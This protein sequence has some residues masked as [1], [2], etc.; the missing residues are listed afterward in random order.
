MPIVQTPQAGEAGLHSLLAMVSHKRSTYSR[1]MA[2][3]D[4]NISPPTP[5]DHARTARPS[6]VIEGG[7]WMLSAGL[8][9]AIMIA[10]IRHASKEIHPFEVAF[11]RNLFGLMWM[12][13]WIV[14]V[15][16]AGLK[17]QR[18][19]L[20]TGRAISGTAAMLTWFWA[21]TLM[22]MTEAVA[23]SFTTPFFATIFA[24]LFLGEIVR[25]RR[26]SA[27]AVGFVGAMVI[28]R[29]GVEAIR[30]ESLVVIASAVCMACS[31]V[32]VKMLSRTESP[33]AIVVYMVMY[34]TPLSLIPALFVW[35]WPSW[36]VLGWLVLLGF[37][38]TLS[39]LCY[40]R[41]FRAADTSAVMP[42]DFSRLIFSA[43]L[44]YIVFMEVADVWTWSGAAIIAGSAIY[45]ARREAIA[46]RERRAAARAAAKGR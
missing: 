15:G 33:N 42:F 1:T 6:N 31:T 46:Q 18:L 23:L 38:A 34:L 11:F 8:G 3:P 25:V 24:V 14:T 36:N 41:A 30:A 39:H 17:T 21:V 5:D 32:F 7:A 4:P 26:W 43:L 10:L 2:T 12:L 28:L 16:W 45:I 9:F 29:P 44:G 27:I 13:P 19:G 20:Y 35:T 22:P 37:V 40:T